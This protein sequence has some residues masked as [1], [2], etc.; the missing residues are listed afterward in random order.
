MSDNCGNSD[1]IYYKQ[2]VHEV[3]QPWLVVKTNLDQPDPGNDREELYDTCGGCFASEDDPSICEDALGC[4]LTDECLV[5]N[6]SLTDAIWKACAPAKVY[7]TFDLAVDTTK[8]TDPTAVPVF[9]VVRKKDE[10]GKDV[11]T[12]PD[13]K[14]VWVDEGKSW[15]TG[16]ERKLGVPENLTPEDTFE[17]SVYSGIPEGNPDDSDLDS[18]TE[19]FFDEKWP[20]KGYESA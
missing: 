17:V 4:E 16:I 11:W 12:A 6:V 13:I 2:N 10:K 8:I 3:T 15:Y 14:P 19:K 5:T 9:F 20:G 7:V 1:G 18:D